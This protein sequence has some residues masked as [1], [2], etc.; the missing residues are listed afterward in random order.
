M[1]VYCKKSGTNFLAEGF[2]H[3]MEIAGEH[4]IFSAPV[5]TLLNSRQNWYLGKL[6]ERESKLLFLALMNSTG[7]VKFDVPAKPAASVIQSNMELLFNFIVWYNDIQL[8]QLKLPKFVINANTC[9]LSNV[10]T[11]LKVW[12][13]CRDDWKEGYASST[14]RERLAQKEATL[15]KLIHSSLKKSDEYAGRLAAWAMDASDAPMNIREYWTELFKLKGLEV[16]NAHTASLEEMLDHMEDNLPI[17]DSSI[18]ANSVLTHIRKIVYRNRAGLNFGLGMPTDELLS[19]DFEKMERDPFRIVEDEIEEQNK[20]DIALTAPEIE[21]IKSA[22]PSLLAF[23]RAKAAWTVS[24]ATKNKAAAIEI[25]VD[26]QMKKD[27]LDI[28]GEDEEDGDENQIEMK[29]I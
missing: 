16:Y 26:K 18:Y 27:G 9:T 19:T 29:D 7:L 14:K 4:P 2:S 6:D 22:Y 24:Q 25:A 15:Y 5:K 23:L 28:V 17:Y 20:A 13:A 3:K 11:W 12:Q 10:N 8:A 21:P 1:K